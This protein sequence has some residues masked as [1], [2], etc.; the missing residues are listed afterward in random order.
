MDV[1]VVEDEKSLKTGD[2]VWFTFSERPYYIQGVLSPFAIEDTISHVAKELADSYSRI[3]KQ[4]RAEEETHGDI[5]A[6]FGQQQSGS[7]KQVTSV[8]SGIVAY[9]D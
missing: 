4:K 1:E 5:L 2:V 7:Q 9:S 6:K 3:G 8:S